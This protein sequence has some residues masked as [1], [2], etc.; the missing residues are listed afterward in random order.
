MTPR[1]LAALQRSAG[2]AAVAGLV[3]GQGRDQSGVV[4]Q[5][6]GVAGVAGG[7]GPRVARVVSAVSVQ[8]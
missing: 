8:R 3:A 7:A 4:D 1:S 2:N 6:A 5:S